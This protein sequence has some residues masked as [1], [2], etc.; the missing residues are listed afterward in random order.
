M[1]LAIVGE[2]VRTEQSGTAVRILCHDFRSV[3]VTFRV[4]TNME[5]PSAGPPAGPV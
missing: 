5:Q 1:R 3:P 4:A 2:V